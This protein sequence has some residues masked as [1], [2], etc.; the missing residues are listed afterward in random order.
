MLTENQV[1]RIAPNL[2]VARIKA[3]TEAINLGCNKYGIN[4]FDILHEFLAN[5]LHESG[6]FSIKAENL[7][8]TSAQRLIAIWPTRFTT[9]GEAGKRNAI[10]FINDPVKLA[11]AVYNGRMG[12][13]VGTNDGF[14]FR[15][16]GYAQ[17]TGKEAY[18]A[19]LNFVNKRDATN[20]TLQQL[21]TL[22][23]T[24]E[25]W[26]FDSAFWFFCIF[27]NLEQLAIDD[28]MNDLVRRWNGGLIGIADR[29][30]H[31]EICKKVLV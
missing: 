11:N 17:I 28:R 27:K 19:Y 26:A 21:T 1:R 8:Y 20:Y 13:L 9:R 12:N 4:S 15:G 14:N 5:L 30:K 24:T 16:G 29:M 25:Q 3:V 23:Q 22:V 31:Y 6:E 2:Q 10:E 7:R 18:Q